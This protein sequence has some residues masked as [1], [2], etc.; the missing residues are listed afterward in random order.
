MV[1]LTLKLGH[2]PIV[3]SFDP[4]V[5]HISLWLSSNSTFSHT[6]SKAE[7]EMIIILVSSALHRELR[8]Q[9]MVL[10]AF[11]KNCCFQS[12]G[13]IGLAADLCHTLWF[14]LLSGSNSFSTELG[15]HEQHQKNFI[16]LVQQV[17]EVF[18]CVAIFYQFT[19]HQMSCHPFKRNSI[20]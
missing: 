4:F 14:S 7:T 3:T 10:N 17:P 5:L 18:S 16:N 15:H 20:I 1:E 2:S 9:H 19:R 13:F 12:S 6:L 11:E 8:T